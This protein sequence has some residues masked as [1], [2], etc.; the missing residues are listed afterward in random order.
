MYFFLAGNKISTYLTHYLPFRSQHPNLSYFFQISF[1]TSW[2]LNQWPLFCHRIHILKPY[3]LSHSDLYT[4]LGIYKKY[5]QQYIS[6][7]YAINTCVMGPVLLSTT[8]QN[9][10]MCWLYSQRKERTQHFIIYRRWL[11]WWVLKWLKSTP[12]EKIHL[13]VHKHKTETCKKPGV[14]QPKERL[15]LQIIKY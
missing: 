5:I 7:N 8:G 9:G 10:R 11:L 1:L 2:V 13:N 4:N 6:L 3:L 14:W 12:E 15:Q